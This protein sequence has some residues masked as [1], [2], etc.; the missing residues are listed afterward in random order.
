MRNS[1][2]NKKIRT[3]LP[4]QVQDFFLIPRLSIPKKIELSGFLSALPN[5]NYFSSVSNDYAWVDDNYVLMKLWETKRTRVGEWNSQPQ[6]FSVIAVGLIKL[7]INLMPFQPGVE[8][9]PDS[10]QLVRGLP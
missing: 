6:F 1:H 10:H 5:T 9:R 8:H 2:R 7:L 4:D 3:C